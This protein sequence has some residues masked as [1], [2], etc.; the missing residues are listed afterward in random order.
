[1]ENENKDKEEPKKNNI[2]TTNNST[3]DK[4]NAH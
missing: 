2:S 4:N 1:M 3:R